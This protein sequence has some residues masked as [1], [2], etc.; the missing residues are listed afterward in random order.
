MLDPPLTTAV[1]LAAGRGTRMRRPLS[2]EL[3]RQL[4]EPQREAAE[5]GLK[6][7]IPIHGIP[8]IAYA[9]SALADAG[10]RTVVV[11]TRPAP[12]PVRTALEAIPTTRL[13]LRFA[14]QPEPRGT[15]H[16]LAHA[17]PEVEPEVEAARPFL[18][19]NGDNLYPTEVLAHMR[20]GSGHALAGFRASDL[21]TLGNLTPDR[22]SAF[23]LLSVDAQ[24]ALAGIV[25]KPDPR[26]REVFGPDP[27][28]SMTCWRFQPS[29]FAVARGLA[30]SPRGEF[31][32]PDAALALRAQGEPVQVIPVR[33]GVLDL[34]D[35]ADIPSVSAR[36]ANAEVRL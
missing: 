9:L 8:F 33:G 5:A 22:I 35:P 30:P 32:L 11:V 19:V 23:A 25:E 29:V 7:L 12:D 14:T 6:A 31:E 26:A 15:A 3:A 28:V 21:S 27:L 13:T 4:T 34:T 2:P 36:L 1:L 16:A 20:Q 18:V 17:E 10:F 24:S